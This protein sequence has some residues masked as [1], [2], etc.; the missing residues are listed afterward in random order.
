MQRFKHWLTEATQTIQAYH[1]S[2]AMFNKFEQGKARLVNDFYGGGVC[3]TTVDKDVAAQYA[4]AML[5]KYKTG[6]RYVY[7]LSLSLNNV[8]DVDYVFT[9]QELTKFYTNK[10]VE[11]FARGAGMLTY[12]VNKYTVFSQLELGSVSL[13]G[14]Q[15]FK[16][17]SRGQINTAT[18]REKLKSLGY[19][20]LRYN[21]GLNMNTAKKH[22][23][24]LVYYAKDVTILSVVKL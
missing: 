14:E 24:Y 9:G 2:N 6:A 1:G 7:H 5:K 10:E 11:A 12:G 22:D 19:D 3:Y 17:L 16:G 15:V 18:T 23:V 8:F 20:G 4:G 21:G 13:T